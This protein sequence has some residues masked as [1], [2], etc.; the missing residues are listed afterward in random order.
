MHSLFVHMSL[1]LEWYSDDMALQPT[2]T[3][4]NSDEED[5]D[6]DEDEDDGAST[7][8]RKQQKGETKKVAIEKIVQR[9]PGARLA[10]NKPII[11]DDDDDEGNDEVSLQF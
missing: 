8:T 1:Y 3:L 11:E 10:K 2:K 7:D 9:K 5:E 4:S 6:D